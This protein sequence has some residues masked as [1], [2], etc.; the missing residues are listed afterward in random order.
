MIDLDYSLS[1]VEDSGNFP[2]LPIGLFGHS[3]GAYCDCGVLTYHPEVKAIIACCGTNSSSD[4]FEIG[5]KEQAGNF[6]YAMM[7]L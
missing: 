4:I 7:H 3:W 6:I 1:F 2:N 5:G